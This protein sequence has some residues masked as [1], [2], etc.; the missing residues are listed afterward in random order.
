MRGLGLVEA[1]IDVSE[2][3]EG[4]DHEA[5]ADEE[6]ESE[7]DLNDDKDAADAVLFA[8]SAVG[9]AAFADA[10][11]EADS[12]VL[13]NG[14]RA[15]EHAR[16]NGDSEGEEQ[17]GRVDAD[18]V[19]ARNAGR[20]NQDEDAQGGESESQADDAAEQPENETF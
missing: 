4:A 3:A 9:A 11:A 15:E 7:G 18:F 5:R 2:R 16:E 8:A 17:D 1:G 10:S 20:S 6:N 19:D 13:E 14:D 12:G